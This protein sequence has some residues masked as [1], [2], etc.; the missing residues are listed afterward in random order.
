M[1][2]SKIKALLLDLDGTLLKV[3]MEIFISTYIK[4]LAYYFSHMA[5]PEKFSKEL[6]ASTKTV[7]AS[8]DP[9]QSN[10]TIFFDEFTRRINQPLENIMPLLEKFYAEEFPRLKHLTSSYSYASS[11]LETARE[12]GLDVVIATNPIFPREAI[13]ERLRWAGI[14]GF[15]FKLVTCL[16]NMHYCKPNPGFY[17]E[18]A[19]KINRDPSFCLM[20]GNDV[21]E[22]LAAGKAGMLTFLVDDTLVNPEEIN[23]C[24]YHWRGSLKEL[25]EFIATI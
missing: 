15:P 25:Q 22:D 2:T 16:E 12:K 1:D 7:V 14:N 8:N 6:M 13:E 11:L 21:V 19:E 3:D 18:I 17:T 23:Q 4:E 5:P 10:E 24:H 20:A 9:N